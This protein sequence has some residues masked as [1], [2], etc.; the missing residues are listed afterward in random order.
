MF[1]RNAWKFVFV[2]LTIFSSVC[3]AA[4][5]YVNNSSLGGDLFC[6]AIGNNAN[7]GTSPAAPKA[8]LKALILTYSSVLTSG[9]RIY[10]D[11]G[12]Y[13]DINI[14]L[15]V[16]GIRISGA[17]PAKTIFDNSGAGTGSSNRLFNITASN[18]TLEDFLVKG[19]TYSVS[20]EA[21][22]IEITSSSNLVL[23]NILAD[24]NTAGGGSTTI[25]ISGGSSVTLNGG[26]SNCNPSGA[27][28]AGG[29]VNVEGNGNNVTFNN[30]SFSNNSKDLQPG[31]ALYVVGDN[32]TTVTVNNSIVADNRCTSNGGAVFIS[33]ANLTV[34]G[35]YFLNNS[36]YGGSGPKYGGAVT[37]GRGATVSFTN[38]KFE[39]NTVS[40]SG[41]GGAISMYTAI[42]G[43]G[44]TAVLNVTNCSFV[45]NSATSGSGNH[46]YARAG[47]SNP[48]QVNINQSTFSSSVTSILNENTATISIQ[49]SGNPSTSGSVS[50]SNTVLAST[51]ATPSY[52][53]LQGSCYGVV[54]PVEFIDLMSSCDNNARL[55]TWS[56]ASEHNNDY[57]TVE[58]GNHQGEFEVIAT[59]GGAG[60]S[61]E[62]LRYQLPVRDA[63]Y[64]RL[65]QTD[66]DGT[67]VELKTISAGSCADSGSE[68]V[69]FDQLHAFDV[70][71]VQT[72]G[73]HFE[74][75][76][77]NSVGQ[78]IEHGSNSIENNKLQRIFLKSFCSDGMYFLHVTAGSV[79]LTEKFMIR[80]Q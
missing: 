4:N 30:Y 31:A 56:V 41:N 69:Y 57:Y 27:T 5:Y 63:A 50:F 11:A 43:A 22:A 59:V 79:V 1:A 53:A 7:S 12:T 24:G 18:I 35:S 37:I 67:R 75:E 14:N 74:Y 17:G 21:S 44:S 39:N 10:V 16:S 36:S 66:Y 68:I 29:G 60:N 15:T 70:F 61:S 45:N 54:L 32:S 25:R 38:C 40:N 49:N 6:T 2:T 71:L 72:H 64:Y 58:A 9:D 48:A 3:H 28:V 8:S 46:I 65:S 76:L 62:E 78:V 23:N 34:S 80:K 13:S 55:L 52:P 77:V 19:Y 20:G 33:G 47:N 42:A 26:G 73:S 51:T